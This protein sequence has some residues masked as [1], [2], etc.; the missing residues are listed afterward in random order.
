MERKVK[1]QVR[2]IRTQDGAGVNLV[3]VPRP[4][5]VYEQLSATGLL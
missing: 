4:Q 3:R 1:Q 2:G 5:R